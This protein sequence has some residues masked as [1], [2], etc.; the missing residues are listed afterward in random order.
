MA[1][2]EQAPQGFMTVSVY[3]RK[4]ETRKINFFFKNEL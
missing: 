2:K 1:S 4:N 3:M